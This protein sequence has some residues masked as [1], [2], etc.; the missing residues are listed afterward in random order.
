MKVY[1][2]GGAVRDKLL[3]LVVTERDWVV[4]GATA[5][6]MLAQGYRQVGRD[7]PVFI[8]PKTHEEYALARTEYKLRAGYYGFSCDANLNVTL[9]E[10][11]KRRDLT[12]NAMAMDEN[13]ILIDPYNGMQDIQN[14]ILRHVSEA[15]IEDPVRVLRVARFLSRYHSLGFTLAPKTR[16]LMYDMV[17]HGELEHLVPERVWQELQRSLQEKHPEKF[18]EVLRACG[19]LAVVLPE[20]D[21]LFG[22]PQT[23]KYHPEIDSG[24]H[25]LMTLAAVS[26]ETADPMTRFAALVHDV[27]KARTSMHHWPKHIGHEAAGVTVIDS[28]CQRL[29]IP[30]DYRKLALLTA[31][32]HLKIHDLHSLRPSTI[33]LVLEQADAFRREERFLQML[34]ACRAD[35][36]GTGRVVEYKQAQEWCELLHRCSQIT[37][38][39]LITKG[40]TGAAI[41]VG[42]HK[43]RVACVK[44]YLHER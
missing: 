38:H 43:L 1:L 37:A 29:R 14:K 17:C 33:V 27:G 22:V 15:F 24:V 8:H 40:C 3:G 12:I 21:A 28:F 39:E 11:L 7:F 42:L 41:K 9:E 32:L 34:T 25:T 23:L 13:G 5:P 35:A 26:A 44:R 2:V 10:D 6:E 30:T 36:L 19:A 18:I 4:V 16:A 20:I 31:R